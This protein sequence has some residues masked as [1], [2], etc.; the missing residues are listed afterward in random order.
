M[1]A[2]RAAGDADCALA[3]DVFVHRLRREIGAM[4]AS[5]GGLD[6]LVMTGGIGEHS[7]E[8]RA[9]GWPVPGLPRRRARP[10]RQRRGHRRRR[11]QPAG[12]AVRTVVVTASEETEIARET[13]QLL[14]GG[15]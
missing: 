8:V 6:L 13:R 10:G 1:L 9:A 11:H 12:A 5:R 14:G 4:T 7:A 3:F 2:G 15:R